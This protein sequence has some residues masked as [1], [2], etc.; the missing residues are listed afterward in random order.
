MMRFLFVILASIFLFTACSSGPLA[1]QDARIIKRVDA[2]YPPQAAA[3]GIEGRVII[4]FTIGKDGVPKDIVIV[5]ANPPGIFEAVSIAAL[6]QW[7]YEPA[8]KL[9]R[10]AESPEAEAVFNFRL[11]NQ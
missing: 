5:E 6:N 4:E 2:D 9:G 3:D 1:P 10:V 7:R 8:R 11:E